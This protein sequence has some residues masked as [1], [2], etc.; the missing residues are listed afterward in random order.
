MQSAL[1]VSTSAT[2]HYLKMKH[3]ASN[4]FTFQGDVFVAFL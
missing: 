4:W 3:V 1:E 2:L